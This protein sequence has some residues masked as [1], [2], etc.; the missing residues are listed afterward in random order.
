MPH[1]WVRIVYIST[2]KETSTVWVEWSREKEVNDEVRE[3]MAIIIHI[4]LCKLLPT[5]SVTRIEA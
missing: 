1:G 5:V 2:S 4:G 3:V